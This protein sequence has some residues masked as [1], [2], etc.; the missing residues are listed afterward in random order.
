MDRSPRR[1]VAPAPPRGAC[2]S[3]LQELVESDPGPLALAGG[4]EQVR[5]Q[6]GDPRVDPELLAL[7]RNPA[8][9]RPAPA[10]QPVPGALGLVAVVAQRDADRLGLGAPEQARLLNLH[11]V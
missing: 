4:G 1:A 5:G 3:S 10:D 6:G 8:H 9:D 11:L 7:E 2:R